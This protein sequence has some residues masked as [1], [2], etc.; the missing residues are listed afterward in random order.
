MV[1]QR[2]PLVM[3]RTLSGARVLFLFS[4]TFAAMQRATLL[5]YSHEE[6]KEHLLSRISSK[7]LPTLC[8]RRET[9]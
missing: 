7:R 5:E 2:H 8:E 1:M 9:A 6:R 4:S 3:R